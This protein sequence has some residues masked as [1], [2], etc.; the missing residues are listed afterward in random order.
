MPRTVIVFVSSL[1]VELTARPVRLGQLERSLTTASAGC[2]WASTYV[3]P[4]SLV[5]NCERRL[6]NYLPT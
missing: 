1:M 6:V 2:F 3:Q 4:P 5:G